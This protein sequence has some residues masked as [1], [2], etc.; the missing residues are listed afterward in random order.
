MQ[1]IQIRKRGEC[2][3][4]AGTDDPSWILKYQDVARSARVEGVGE[5]CVRRRIC[6]RRMTIAAVAT[7][8]DECWDRTSGCG[9]WKRCEFGSGFA[10]WV[11]A[12][13]LLDSGSG[14][15]TLLCKD[16]SGGSSPSSEC[17]QLPAARL[18]SLVSVER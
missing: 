14:E 9:G 1:P 6:C 18:A 3:V 8:R 10:C 13:D 2:V 12:R 4:T 17:K 7:E 15:D 5:D 16:A 11:L